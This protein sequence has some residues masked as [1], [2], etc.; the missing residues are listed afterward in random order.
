MKKIPVT[1][2]MLCAMGLQ[3]PADMPP[4]SQV[5]LTQGSSNSWNL[6]WDGVEDLTDTTKPV[7][8]LESPANA[9]LVSGP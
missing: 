7:V 8:L 6:D 9:V 5:S 2:A 1:F 4:Q 3:A